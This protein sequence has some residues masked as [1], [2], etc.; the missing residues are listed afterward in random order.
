MKNSLETRLG[1]FV[2]LVVFAAWAIIETL[3]G[4]DLFQRRLPRQRPVQHRAGIEG[5]RQRENGRRGNRPRRKN[6]ARRRQG[7]GHDETSPDAVVKT[8]SKAVI[9]FTGLMG[10]NFVSID[11]GSP[12][13]P[14]AVD[15]E[16]CCTT[17]NSRTSTPSWP[18]WTT[19]PA[20][21]KRWPRVF[22]ATKSTTCSAR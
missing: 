7:Q 17:G 22:P 21:C 6:R 9:K 4:M 15:G 8:D 18:S 13:A 2:V 16:R 19:P 12:D 10:Q 1:I 5:G 14:P 3:G 20:A 11:F